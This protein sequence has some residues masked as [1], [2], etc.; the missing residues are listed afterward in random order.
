M[1]HKYFILKNIVVQNLAE[2]NQGCEWN[3][4][5]VDVALF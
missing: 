2:G 5:G 3:G 4:F 1:T